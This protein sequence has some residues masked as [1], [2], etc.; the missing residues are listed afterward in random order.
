MSRNNNVFYLSF[1]KR[2]VCGWFLGN[3]NFYFPFFFV[4][5]FD[6]C[7]LCCELNEIVKTNQMLVQSIFLYSDT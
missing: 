4:L 3:H 1:D 5:I 7:G 6:F 2:T